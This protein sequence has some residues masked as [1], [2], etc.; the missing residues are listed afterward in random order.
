MSNSNTPVNVQGLMT[1]RSSALWSCLLRCLSKLM[2]LLCVA[3]CASSGNRDDSAPPE[4]SQSTAGKSGEKKSAAATSVD[5]SKGLGAGG[6]GAETLQ[7]AANGPSLPLEGEGWKPLF[8]GTSFAGWRETEFAGRGEIEIIS[9]LIVLNMGNPFT[10]ISWTNEFPKMNY[11]I[12]LDAMRI[13]GSDFFCGLT[14]PVGN[15][16]CSWIVGGW[17]GSL[18]GISSIDSMDASENETTR[19]VNFE[20]DRWYRLRLRV[21]ED[22]IQAWVDQEKLIDVATTGKRISVR[23][24]DIEL[25]TPVGLSAWQTTAVYRNIKLR[26]ISQP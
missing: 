8:D 25:S 24:G 15:N 13:G 11:E 26:P 7:E 17:G 2:L 16:F 4:G 23:P 12:A 5:Q 3:G 20:R 22:R 9:G 14:I 1:A 10:G 6:R 19:F 21:T 18:V